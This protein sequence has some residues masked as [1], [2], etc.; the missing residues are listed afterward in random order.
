[1]ELATTHLVY[2]EALREYLEKGGGSR[3]SYIV[4]DT[5]G[6][7]PSEKLSSEW[8]YKPFDDTLMDRVCEIWLNENNKTSTE[9]INVRQIPKEEGWF[10]NIWE[11]YRKGQIIE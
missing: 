6:S 10:E 9:W 4:L 7:C 3:G 2:L 11:K 1:M 5:N 8:F